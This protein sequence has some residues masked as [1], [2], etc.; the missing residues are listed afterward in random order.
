LPIQDGVTSPS[1][2]KTAAVVAPASV[3]IVVTS[4]SIAWS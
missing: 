4:P 2:P 1:C 3:T